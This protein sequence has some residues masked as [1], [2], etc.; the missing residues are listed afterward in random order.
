M[1][2]SFF[3]LKIREGVFRIYW[4]SILDSF[5]EIVWTNQSRSE[6]LH[7][8]TM[9]AMVL[10]RIGSS[11]DVTVAQKN[12]RILSIGAFWVSWRLLN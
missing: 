1:I 5:S 4:A 7:L 12:D 8:L 11:F 6:L 2:L 9:N 3:S 10:P